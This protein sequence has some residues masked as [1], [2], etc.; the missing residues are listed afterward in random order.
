MSPAEPTDRT[1]ALLEAARGLIES[2]APWSMSQL[3]SAAKVSRAT[4]Y[5]HFRSRSELEQALRQ[6]GIEASEPPAS[7]RERCLDAVASLATS[8]GLPRM[9]MESVADHAGI[10]VATVYRIFGTRKAL[11]RAFT[12]ERSPRAV[13][14]A[15]ML[16]A[17]ASLEQALETLVDAVL[18]Q[19]SDHAPW[20]GLSFAADEESRELVAELVAVEREAR[21]GLVAFMARQ[22]DAGALV[23]DPRTLAQALL[24]LAAGQALFARADARSPAPADARQL[25][26]LFLH[27]AR[28]SPQ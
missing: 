17:D 24:S 25:V 16:D 4:V 3:A 6:A 2:G 8:R 11:L 10:G 1:R 13:L 27:G 20:F 15:V 19:V 12:A 7:A 26:E 22:V 28:P 21:A 23:G 14:D 9:T 5:R 18:R